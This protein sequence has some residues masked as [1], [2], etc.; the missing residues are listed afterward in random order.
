M[1]RGR[2]LVRFRGR[3]QGGTARSIRR[4][5]P[6]LLCLLVLIVVLAGCDEAGIPARDGF[7]QL[8]TFGVGSG[9]SSKE[10]SAIR[11][12]FTEA[13]IDSDAYRVTR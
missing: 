10:I 12:L 3:R 4:R 5:G 8:G 7:V 13:G 2:L 9:P 11:K 1:I 6:L